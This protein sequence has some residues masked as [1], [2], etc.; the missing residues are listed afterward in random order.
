VRDVVASGR[1]LSAAEVAT[2]FH[3]APRKDVEGL[4]ESL[5]AVGVLTAFEVSGRRRWR[6]SGKPTA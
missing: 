5:T 3:R 6:I 4:L 1:S 2:H